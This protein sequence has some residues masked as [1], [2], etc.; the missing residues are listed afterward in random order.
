[1]SLK[2]QKS[3]KRVTVLIPTVVRVLLSALWL[4]IPTVVTVL[5]CLALGFKRK[6]TGP[7]GRRALARHWKECQNA[8]TVCKD[9]SN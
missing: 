5:L 8:E 2:L 1:M 4:L 6:R 9:S 7:A 3:S